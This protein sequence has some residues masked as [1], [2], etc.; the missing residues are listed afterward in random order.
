MASGAIGQGGEPAPDGSPSAGAYSAADT[1]GQEGQQS[2]SPYG[3]DLPADL[4]KFPPEKQAIELQERAECEAA[5]AGYHAPKIADASPVLSCPIDL[6]SVKTG[7][8]EYDPKYQPPPFW[9]E[10][11]LV[12]IATAVSS[13]GVPYTVYAGTGIDSQQ[14]VVFVLQETTDPCAT[15]AGLLPRGE[16]RTFVLPGNSGAV[17]LTAIEGDL[18]SFETADGTKGKFDYTAGQ[19]VSLPAAP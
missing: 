3:C 15:A 12:N 4:D 13:Q 8:F 9:R 5:E 16:L 2:E 10:G 6:A 1:I 18:V 11:T 19:F 7:I 17:T 14:G